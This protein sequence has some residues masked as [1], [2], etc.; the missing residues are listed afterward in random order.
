MEQNAKR[1]RR[2][3]LEND[4]ATISQFTEMFRSNFDV[5]RI[6]A[7]YL[8]VRDVINLC[9]VDKTLNTLCETDKLL[10]TYFADRLNR[11]KRKRQKQFELEFTDVQRVVNETLGNTVPSLEN[12]SYK[13]QMIVWLAAQYIRF[14]EETRLYVNNMSQIGITVDKKSGIIALRSRNWSRFS[15]FPTFAET[16]RNSFQYI[17]YRYT[18][19]FDRIQ[20]I[21]SL[22]VKSRDIDVNGITM[23]ATFD[24][25]QRNYIAVILVAFGI[26]EL[27]L[28]FQVTEYLHDEKRYNISTIRD[29]LCDLCTQQKATVEC[30]DCKEKY[31]AECIINKKECF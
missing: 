26:Q 5:F 15:K 3:V 11:L 16:F 31:C 22:K 18:E 30:S 7:Q 2:A 4:V 24:K 29:N 21:F 8:S 9:Q 20:D 23:V 13:R 17:I 28:G 1:L 12:M 10:W 6:M 19:I 14:Y 27:E 25:M